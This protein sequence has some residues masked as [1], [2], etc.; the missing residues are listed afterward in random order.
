MQLNVHVPKAREH[1]VRELE[2]AV[3]DSGQPKSELV[4]DAIEQYLRRRQPRRAR[5]ELPVYPGM[6]A[7]GSLRRADVYEDRLDRRL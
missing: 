3:G 5:F 1:V 6:A 4:L 2:A 7:V